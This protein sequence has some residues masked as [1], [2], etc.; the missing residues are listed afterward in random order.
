[1]NA[2][3][4]TFPDKFFDRVVGN[5][6]LHHLELPAAMMEINRILKPGAKAIFQEPLGEN[7][8]LRLYRSIAGIHT[9]DERP[10]R[11]K[12]LI[13][14]N[15]RWRDQDEIFRSRDTPCFSIHIRC[16]STISSEL[17]PSSGN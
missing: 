14:L 1:M 6:I 2:H 16:S 15:G 12:D 4:T 11:R 10:L 3:E 8:L 5:G 17:A 9:L 7:P 13:Y